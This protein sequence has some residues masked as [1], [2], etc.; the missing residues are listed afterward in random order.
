[1]TSEVLAR[2]SRFQDIAAQ[3]KRVALLSPSPEECRLFPHATILSYK[4]WDLNQAKPHYRFDLIIA[5]N[6]FH[7]SSNPAQWFKSVLASCRVFLM[8]DIVSRKRS[9]ESE[10]ASD[11]DSIRYRIGDAIPNDSHFFDLNTLGDRL[12]GYEVYDGGSNCYGKSVQLL[13]LIKGDLDYPL[14]RMDDY[15]TGVRPILSDMSPLH[16]ILEK[17]DSQG[18]PVHLGI[19]PKLL[20]PSMCVFLKS[21]NYLVPVMHGVDHRYFEFSQKLMSCEDPYN[22]KGTVGR[23]N[24]FSWHLPRTIRHKIKEGKSILE[25]C[26]QRPITTYI[27]P[28]NVCDYFTAQILK[29]EGFDLCLSE[30]AIW[31]QVF[32]VLKSDYY[33]VSTTCP[34]DD[35]EVV[36]L[37]LTWEWDL[38]R[39]GNLDALTLFLDRLIQNRNNKQ[40]LIASMA[41]LFHAH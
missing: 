20:S 14:I 19:V 8:A 26:F 4:D 36:C 37:H 24:E 17:F 33:G 35:L 23:F 22:D 13:A 39:K 38:Q 31:R 3:F 11:G 34:T 21:L 2:L 5:S 25:S 18:I 29:A 16:A 6:V 7:Y 1:M 12:L 9:K 15:P 10:F 30:K 28:C 27:P 32:P 40:S 41:R